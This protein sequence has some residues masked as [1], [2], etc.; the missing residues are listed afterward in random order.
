MPEN[1]H[2][3]QGK[4][5]DEQIKDAI[6]HHIPLEPDGYRQVKF[7]DTLYVQVWS[8]NPDRTGVFELEVIVPHDHNDGYD[9]DASTLS[10]IDGTEELYDILTECVREVTD[11]DRRLEFHLM[12]QVTDGTWER[13][14]NTYVTHSLEAELTT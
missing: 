1:S 10:M 4:T 3:T 12:E 2:Y 8:P 7:S 11:Y 13:D 9:T 6:K 14:A 5:F